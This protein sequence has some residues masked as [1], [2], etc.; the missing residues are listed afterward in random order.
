MSSYPIVWNKFNL[1]QRVLTVAGDL[2]VL[3][4]KAYQVRK[5]QPALHKAAWTSVRQERKRQ[6]CLK[7]P[8]SCIQGLQHEKNPKGKKKPA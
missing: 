7:K 4:G 1:L 5:L 8:G 2:P 3:L 6:I